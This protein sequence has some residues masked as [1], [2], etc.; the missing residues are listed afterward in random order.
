MQTIDHR[1]LADHA[2]R[3][4]GKVEG[5]DL[6]VKADLSLLFL[7]LRIRME[8][9]SKPERITLLI[10]E[11]ARKPGTTIGNMIFHDWP[12]IFEGRYTSSGCEPLLQVADFLAY[13][14]NRSTYLATKRKRTA[15]DNWFSNLVGEMKINSSDVSAVVLTEDFMVEG[16]DRLH[17]LDRKRKGLSKL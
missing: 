16:F 1:T 12:E 11:G 2:I 17:D 10:D 4:K 8:Y 9:Q 15:I 13:C 5:L 14:I 6:S 7:L 3:L